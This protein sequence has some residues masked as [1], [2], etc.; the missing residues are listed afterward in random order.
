MGEMHG[1]L[2]LRDDSG[3]L[4]GYADDV[5][6][7]VR[8]G[9]RARLTIRFFDG[10]LSDE[11]AMYTQGKTL[12]LLS[13]HLIE[14]GPSFPK[15]TDMT[16]DTAKG[17]VTYHDGKDGKDELKTDSLELPAD[18]ANGLLPMLLQNIPRGSGEIKVGYIVTSPKPRVVTLAVHPEGN[19][20]YKVGTVRSANHYRIHVELGGV[21]GV[22][23]PIIGKEPPD[24]D[25]WVTSGE[26]PTILKLR[27]ILYVGG[28]LWTLQLFSPAL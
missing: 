23:A 3:K 7:P 17:T 22:V 24:F 1:F 4:I 8:G 2:T 12:H 9:W 26:A 15:P 13:D 14:K 27:A 6:V 21:A 19:E 5:N 25:A 10:S 11:T 18:L 20:S 16:I 28:P